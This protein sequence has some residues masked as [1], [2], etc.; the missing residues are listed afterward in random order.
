M[1]THKMTMQL[2][3][4]LNRNINKY[5]SLMQIFKSTIH[6]SFNRLLYEF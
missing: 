1:K 5:M 4:I 6:Y 3:Y 2:E